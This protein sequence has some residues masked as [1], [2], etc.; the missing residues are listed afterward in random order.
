MYDTS[1]STLGALDPGVDMKGS[2]RDLVSCVSVC[3]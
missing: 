2:V 3:L 1:V